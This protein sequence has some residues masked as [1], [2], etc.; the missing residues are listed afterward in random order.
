MGLG[1]SRPARPAYIAPTPQKTPEQLRAEAQQH[2]GIDTVNKYNIAF[3]GDC[4]NGKSSLINAW[5]RV[6]KGEKEWAETGSTETTMKI[7]PYEFPP[8]K[9]VFKA[10]EN[11]ILWDI[12]GASTGTHPSKTYIEDKKLYAFDFV[13]VLTGQ[14]LT[15]NDMQYA[16]AVASYGVPFAFVRSKC[17][18][19]LMSDFEDEEGEV[20]EADKEHFK[21]AGT[22]TFRKY[23]NNHSALSS[24]RLYFVSA[25]A[26]Q[27]KRN[28]KKYQL[29]ERELLRDVV[30]KVMERRNPGADCVG[31]YLADVAANLGLAER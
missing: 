14:S 11:V 3:A 17:D 15:E 10:M 27:G 16:N 7:A 24:S 25:M 18:Q 31:V 4:K 20:K 21:A 1:R 29:D 2:L 23:L 30:Y 13:I 22:A 28:Y 26:L 5:R 6:E 9:P 8:D 19:N 12:P